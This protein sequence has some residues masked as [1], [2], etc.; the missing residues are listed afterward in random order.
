VQGALASLQGL[1]AIA[2]PLIAG[3]LFGLFTG[4][5]SPLFFPGAPFLLAA[6]MFGVA[7]SAIQ[8]LPPAR[9]PMPAG[10]VV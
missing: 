3:W 10:D 9:L 6:L 4:S 1:T 7:F 8:G 2:A 5:A